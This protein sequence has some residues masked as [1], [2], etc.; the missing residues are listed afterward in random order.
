MN[1]AYSLWFQ[2]CNSISQ[3]LQK[4]QYCTANLS[5]GQHIVALSVIWSISLKYKQPF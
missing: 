4:E 1:P 3:S 2:L 5:N